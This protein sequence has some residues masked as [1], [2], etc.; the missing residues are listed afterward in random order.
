MKRLLALSLFALALF[1][2]VVPDLTHAQLN[3]IDADTQI[4]SSDRGFVPCS[5]VTCSACDLVSLAN[6]IIDWLIGFLATVF[7]IVI[8]V[9]GLGLAS[10]CGYEGE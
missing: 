10:S 5:G 2:M 4:N 7:A 9:A 8:V 3:P 1:V 6:T